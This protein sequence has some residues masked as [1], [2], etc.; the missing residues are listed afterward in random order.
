MEVKVIEVGLRD[1][2]QNESKMIPTEAKQQI[3]QSLVDAG[4]KHIEV[5]SFVHPKWIPQLADAEALC[6]QLPRDPSLTL[7]ALVP[8]VKGLARALQYPLD[9]V[10]VFISAS[11]THNQKNVNRSIQESLEEIAQVVIEALRQNRRV[12]GYISMVFGCPYEGKV[13]IKQVIHI[14]EALFQCGVHEVSLGDTIGVATPYE[15]KRML[16]QLVPTFSAQCLAGHFHDTRGTGLAN[17]YVS[18]ESGITT[19]DSSLGGLGGCPYAPGASGNLATEDLLYMLDREGL[20]TGIDLDQLVKTSQFL[21]GL[22]NQSLPSKALQ[23]MLS[24]A[25][26]GVGSVDCCEL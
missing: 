23:A 16:Q 26:K 18:L 10:A 8:N 3:L 17:A 24:Q 5:T 21:Q 15:V 12:R 7:S 1:G 20:D 14:C 19:L 11:E 2:L 4:V 6:A 22:M 9:E 13:P 25:E